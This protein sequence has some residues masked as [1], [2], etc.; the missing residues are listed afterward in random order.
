MP[1]RRRRHHRTCRSFGNGL[2]LTIDDLLG[3]IS[4]SLK[5]PLLPTSETGRKSMIA[6]LANSSRVCALSK[7]QETVLSQTR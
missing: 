1:C 4:A 6:N 7:T 2:Q 3:R 5:K